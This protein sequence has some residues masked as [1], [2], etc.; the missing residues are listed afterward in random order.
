MASV[1]SEGSAGGEKDLA[2][3]SQYY[4]SLALLILKQLLVESDI[5][6]LH[7]VLPF[8]LQ[9][10][11]S[12]SSSTHLFMLSYLLFLYIQV[13]EQLPGFFSHIYKCKYK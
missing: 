11:H 2:P 9:L 13:L 1:T 6:K 8:S 12:V 3:L 7:T 5:L 4:F 10:L